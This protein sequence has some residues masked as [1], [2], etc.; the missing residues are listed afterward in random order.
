MNS[1][2]IWRLSKLRQYHPG[3]SVISGL[4]PE[5]LFEYVRSFEGMD[6]FDLFCSVQCIGSYFLSPGTKVGRYPLGSYDLLYVGSG[7]VIVTVD[8]K[9]TTLSKNELFFSD[10]AAPYEVS[11]AG[12]TSAT[13][14]LL[15]HFGALGDKYSSLMSKTCRRRV[16]AR[17]RGV[18]E[19][20]MDSMASYMRYPIQTNRILSVNI[21]TQLLTEVYISSLDSE[22]HTE[23][24]QPKWLLDSL[25]YMELHYSKKI[26]IGDIAENCG[27]SSS[28]FY[29]L[30]RKH[31]GMTPYEYL[32]QLRISVAKQLL[33]NGD[34]SV[35]YIAYAV[36]IPSV[37][38]FIT[39]FREETGMTPDEYRRA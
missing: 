6:S 9:Q 37:S 23:L 20:L 30:F 14:I 36:G 8:S 15:S 38:H 5:I 3:F 16:T 19:N 33:H 35:K 1:E 18:I 28:H 2:S 34:D 24:G 32:T 10:N 12:Q 11:V 21:L 7:S 4:A 29:R 27:L 26:S 22:S 39:Y 17:S 13:L 25:N 31:I